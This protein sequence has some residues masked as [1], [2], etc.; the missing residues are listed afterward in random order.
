MRRLARQLPLRI[1]TGAFIL[2]S[3]L[4]KKDADEMTANGLR[5][6]A[7]VTYPFL[8]KM[9][10]KQFVSLLSKAEIA[11]GAALIVPF[12]PAALAGA[13]LTVFSLGML[14]L[15]FKTPGMRRP[16][17]L[18][19]TQQGIALAKDVWLLGIGLSLMAD[20]ED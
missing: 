11:L 6:F 15:Y 14:G 10:S 18:G 16:A 7:A 1:A 5:D 19:P 4:S 8:A 13:G 2:D 12:V 17:G 9:D 20:R 3:G